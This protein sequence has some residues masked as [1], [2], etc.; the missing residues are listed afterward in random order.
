[1]VLRV[2]KRIMSLAVD[3]NLIL[4]TERGTHTKP[5][6]INTI[7]TKYKMGKMIKEIMRQ[8]I[9]VYLVTILR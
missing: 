8:L 3:L 4:I 1:M 2:V 6:L 9:N 5:Y 7:K